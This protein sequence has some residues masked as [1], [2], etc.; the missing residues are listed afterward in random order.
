[1]PITSAIC[2]SF[3]KEILEGVHE[4]T[5]TYKLALIKA[6][7]AGTYGA[8]T[9]NYSDVTGN[10]DEVSG[11]GYSAGGVTL[12]G[13]T[14]GSSGTTA[15][16]DWTT[17]PAWASATIS[18]DGFIIYNSSQGNKAVCVVDFGGTHT[19]THTGTFSVTFPAADA[20]NALIR[21]T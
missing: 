1:M 12:S 2:T 15:W 20:S 14:T 16:I 4:S 8:A 3:K 21:L 7:P 6:S 5:D 10:S 9:V 11:T 17:D 18:A 13:F 19:V